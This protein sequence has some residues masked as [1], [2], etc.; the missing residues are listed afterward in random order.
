MILKFYIS[1]ACVFL[2]CERF[3]HTSNI[4]SAFKFLISGK[5]EIKGLD[6]Q[7]Y[8]FQEEQKVLWTD[9][10][11]NKDVWTDCNKIKVLAHQG[12]SIGWYTSCDHQ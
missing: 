10:K 2:F 4:R 7:G 12:T 5:K 3:R 8:W 11:K 9:Q 1:F 6:G